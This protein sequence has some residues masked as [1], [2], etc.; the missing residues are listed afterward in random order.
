MAS[1]GKRESKM[2]NGTV[3]L[4]KKTRLDLGSS[5]VAAEHQAYE[6]LGHKVILQLISSV[7]GDPDV[8]ENEV[9]DFRCFIQNTGV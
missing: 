2:I 6:I 1:T 9:R 3:L 7:H 8:Q 5:E 4:T